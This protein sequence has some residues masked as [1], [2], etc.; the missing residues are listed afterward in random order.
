MSIF[1]PSL[2]SSHDL[3]DTLKAYRTLGEPVVHLAEAVM[4]KESEL[5]IGERELIA[6]Y[7]SGLNACQYCVNSHIN[8]AEQFGV[9]ATVLEKL[10]ASIDDAPIKETLK[11]IFYYV[12]KLTET[13]SKMM[14]RDAEQVYSLGWQEETL[15]DVVSVC[16]FFSLMN[17][18]V[19]GTG[20]TVNTVAKAPEKTDMS[21]IEQTQLATTYLAWG[22]LKGIVQ[23]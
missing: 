13:P 21:A 11:P 10:L 20:C 19:D 15:V 7:V 1:L 4:R 2:A 18:L 14:A 16:A 22:R 12:K 3:A 6:A 9:D 17:R 5:S 8:V 23:N